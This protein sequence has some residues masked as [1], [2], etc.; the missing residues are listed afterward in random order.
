M[1]EWFKVTLI[2]ASMLLL[3]GAMAQETRGIDP[4]YPTVVAN[5]NVWKIYHG[6]EFA[7]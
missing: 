5:Q 1:I 2:L 7:A 4:N 3:P 6:R